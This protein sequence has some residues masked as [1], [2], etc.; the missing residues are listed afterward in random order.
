MLEEGSSFI[1]YLTTK[2]R[3][4]GKPHT[5]PLRLI[6]CCGKIYASRRDTQSDW[7]RNLLQN[8]NVTVE[9]QGQRFVGTARLISDEAL[10]RKVSELKYRDERTLKKRVVIEMTLLT[11]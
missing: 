1:G 11:S 4:I 6:C 7:C 8:P 2:G 3:V 5:V 9:I 10:C